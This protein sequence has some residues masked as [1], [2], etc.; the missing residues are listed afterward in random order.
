MGE[1]CLANQNSIFPG[2]VQ[3]G[4]HNHSKLHHSSVWFIMPYMKATR[5][6][7]D[8][9]VQG[10]T[11]IERVIWRLPEPTP[12][13]PHGYKY[14]LYCG[15]NGKSLV[16]YDNETGK[17]DHIH[18]EDVEVPYRFVSLEQLLRDFH[19]DV[20]QAL[21]GENGKPGHH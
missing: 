6:L 3:W 4:H 18:Y 8:K 14:R 16:R 9:F 11:I 20:N 17:G 21:N 5:I 12:E 13:R 15:K 10:N 2:T 7:R 19:K 1:G